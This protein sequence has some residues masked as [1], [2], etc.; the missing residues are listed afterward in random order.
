MLHKQ[1]KLTLVGISS[2]TIL[3]TVIGCKV[4]FFLNSAWFYILIGFILR[5]FGH[6]KQIKL[7]FVWSLWVC[8]TISDAYVLPIESCEQASVT[9][10]WNINVLIKLY[11]SGNKNND[12]DDGEDHDDDYGDDNNDDHD[13]DTDSDMI[14]HCNHY[15][16]N[17][18]NNWMTIVSRLLALSLL[19]LYTRGIRR[20]STV[21]RC[22][23]NVRHHFLF[24]L[25]RR[26]NLYISI[27]CDSFLSWHSCHGQRKPFRGRFY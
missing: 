9:F 6:C 26:A 27:K 13:D 11:K 1:D 14:L 19:T 21:L 24:S 16:Q 15:N 7:V 2:T 17:D 3:Y 5:F 12:D 8:S 4:W 23:F 25:C 10:H 20:N 22:F 18:H